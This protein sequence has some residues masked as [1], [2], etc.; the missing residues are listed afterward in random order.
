MLRP[1][2]RILTYISYLVLNNYLIGFNKQFLI[3]DHFYNKISVKL[4]IILYFT[5]FKKRL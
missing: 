4:K 2:T 1:K 5:S 3:T